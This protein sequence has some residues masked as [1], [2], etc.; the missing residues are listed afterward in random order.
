MIEA[1]AGGFSGELFI[2]AAITPGNENGTSK[3]NA[4]F[5][6]ATS[7]AGVYRRD[8]GNRL[9]ERLPLAAAGDRLAAAQ[10]AQVLGGHG[11]KR[12]SAFSWHHLLKSSDDARRYRIETRRVRRHGQISDRCRTKA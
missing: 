4:D 1:F 2:L 8:N 7:K 12:S 5:T 11:K 9:R 10:R 3:A 6:L